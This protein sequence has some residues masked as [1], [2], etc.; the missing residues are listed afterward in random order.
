V[1]NEEPVNLYSST[2][3]IRKIRLRETDGKHVG[4]VGKMR[5]T[6]EILLCIPESYAYMGTV[7]KIILNK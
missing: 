7:F 6:Y 2:Y 3:I 4:D 5:N 1:H